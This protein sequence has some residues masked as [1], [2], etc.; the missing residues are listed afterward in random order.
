MKRPLTI[1][2]PFLLFASVALRQDAHA[3]DT[4]YTQTAPSDNAPVATRQSGVDGHEPARFSR[5]QWGLNETEWQQYMSLMRG[6]RGSISQPNL[7][8]L[9]VLGIHAETERERR[10]Y[11]ARLAKML[12]EDNERV[13]AFTRAYSE[14]ASKLAKAMP[15]IDLSRL[16]LAKPEAETSLLDDDRVL[17]FTRTAPCQYCSLQLKRLLAVTSGK[18]TQFDIYLVD[19]K[20]DDAIRGWV[21]DNALPVERIKA[22]MTTLNYDKGTLARLAGIGNTVPTSF[23]LRGGRYS[24][25][26]PLEIN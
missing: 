21:K 4:Q 23:L 25:L 12:I 1:V 22:G 6:I 5:E 16:G 20:N 15:T 7:S 9:E 19:A 13:L 8:P 10:D 17:F 2:F 24:N 14:E 3:V 26:N 18:K 11:A